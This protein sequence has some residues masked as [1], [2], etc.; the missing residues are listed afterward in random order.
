[1]QGNSLQSMATTERGIPPGN[2]EADV[3]VELHP[4]DHGAP[5]GWAMEIEEMPLEAVEPDFSQPFDGCMAMVRMNSA[6]S[7]ASSSWGRLPPTVRSWPC[8]MG[9]SF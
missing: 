2:E 6:S 7:S 9:I 3:F 8:D 1:M 5:N 4:L